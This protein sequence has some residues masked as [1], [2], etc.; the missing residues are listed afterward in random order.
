MSELNKRHDY[1]GQ[2]YDKNSADDQYKL[3]EQWRQF[4]EKYSNTKGLLNYGHGCKE[5]WKSCLEMQRELF[6]LWL[7]TFSEMQPDDVATKFGPKAFA[8]WQRNIWKQWMQVQ[9]NFL[10][11]CEKKLKDEEICP[12]NFSPAETM[13]DLYKNWLQMLDNCSKAALG[14]PGSRDNDNDT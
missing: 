12:E 2:N 7:K 14:S 10:K 11:E 1:G 4:M 6:N 9:K 13:T 5:G 3:F 8:H